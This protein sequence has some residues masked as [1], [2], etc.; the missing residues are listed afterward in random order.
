MGT[1]RKALRNKDIKVNGNRVKED[2]TLR[3]N[4][5]IEIFLPN[6]FSNQNTPKVD[7]PIVFEDD[8]ILIVN[9]PQ[10]IAVHAGD[11]EES[12]KSSLTLIK[13]LQQ[14]TSSELQLC[15]RIDRNTGGLVLLAKNRIAL[16]EVLDAIENHTIKKFYRC[17]VYGEPKPPKATLTNYL[18]KNSRLSQVFVHATREKGD[19]TAITTYEVLATNKKLSL[20]DVAISTGRM[21]QIRAQLSYAGY[22]I[23]GDGKYGNTVVNR[24][25]K[26]KI[27]QLFAYR[28]EFCF[29]AKSKLNYLSG[30]SVE[31]PTINE[32][33]LNQFDISEN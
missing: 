9:K 8:N 10:G 13:L 18:S 33:T 31:I 14:Q 17:I 3:P 22:P 16:E 19:L 30:T 26:T 28:L 23:L 6:N 21:H 24:K 5:N 4:D 7:I 25:F 2:M 1:A 12:D 15:H 29:S 20:L 32:E 27:Q 11:S